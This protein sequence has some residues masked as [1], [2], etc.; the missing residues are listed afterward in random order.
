MDELVTDIRC[1]SGGDVDCNRGGAGRCA[2]VFLRAAAEALAALTRTA[3][4]T[5]WAWEG[6]RGPRIWT[7][8]NCLRGWVAATAS[9]WSLLWEETSGERGSRVDERADASVGAGTGSWASWRIVVPSRTKITKTTKTRD[10]ERRRSEAEG[11]RDRRAG[12]DRGGAVAGGRGGEKNE[13]GSE[14]TTAES[15]GDHEWSVLSQQAS[16]AQDGLKAD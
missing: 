15:L 2:I 12:L 14:R 4:R 11:K 16:T 7:K 6:L 10:G 13:R 8:E 3:L 1:W 9:S 5:F